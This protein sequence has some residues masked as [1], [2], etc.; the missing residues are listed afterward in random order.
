M[1]LQ[2]YQYA[3]ASLVVLTTYR[4]Y[5]Y[6]RLSARPKDFPPGP[7]TAPVIG[8][9]HQMPAAMPHVKFT[10]LGRQFGAITGM[11]VG[12][13]NWVILNSWQAVR[14]LIDQKGAIYSSRPRL[15][16]VEIVAPGGVSPVTNGYNDMWRAQRKKLVEFLGGERTDRMKPVQDAE[17]TQMIWD[18]LTQPPEFL[19]AHVE[20]SYGSTIFETV[21]GT[22]DKT[23]EPTSWTHIFFDIEKRWT[24]VVDPGVA[25]PYGGFPFL[26]KLPIWLSPW[27]AWK[28]LA[29]GVRRDQRALYYALFNETKKRLAEGKANDCFLSQCLRVQEKDGVNDD[30]IAYLGGVLIEGGAETSASTTMVFIMAMAA[31]PHVL[32]LAQEEIDRVVGRDRMPSR[33]DIGRLPYIKACMQEVTRWRPIIPIGVPH[34]TVKSDMHGGM[35]IPD[36]STVI[37]NA[38]GI[39]M[40]ETFYDS[41]ATFNPDRYLYNEYGSTFA[42]TNPEAMKGRRVSYSFGA[43]RR[44]CPGQ[45]FA[46][47]S[48]IMHFSKLVWAF[49]F[50][51]TGHLPVEGWDGWQ[52]GLAIRPKDLKV[53]LRLRDEGRRSVIQSAW[54][55]ADSFLSQFE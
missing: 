7:K 34:Q 19:E 37:I 45:R 23:I 15:P 29:L 18:I 53:D 42:A 33:D 4:L 10:E 2:P 24:V 43:G 8:N 11:K 48:L 13:E 16:G 52:E 14:D 51:K 25:P 36:D 50:I 3:I 38:F 28:K 46:E 6:S 21:F 17:S 47:N 26:R 9:L 54:E 35:V 44:V 1:D 5:Q 30:F 12:V 20:R 55:E 31:F 32:A 41:P 39:N 49:D 27:R 22:R 40:D